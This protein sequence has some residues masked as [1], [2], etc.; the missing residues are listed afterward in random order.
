MF[1]WKPFFWEIAEKLLSYR[2]KQDELL[3][4][5]REMRGEGMPVISLE[6]QNPRGNPIPLREVDPF[7]FFACFNRASLLKILPMAAECSIS[8]RQVQRF[9][10][11][12]NYW[13]GEESDA[14]Q[15]ER[16]I[17]L[18]TACFFS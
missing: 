16:S 2:E 18:R 10:L 11:I 1:T 5:L 12:R 13:Q 4:W 3:A 9:Q 17:Q 15:I 8:N 6:D 14:W 7:T